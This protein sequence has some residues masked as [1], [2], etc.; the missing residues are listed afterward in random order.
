MYIMCWTRLLG[1]GSTT[2]QINVNTIKWS[3]KSYTLLFI[4]CI[5]ILT[6]TRLT[7]LI[8]LIRLCDHIVCEGSDAPRAQT[9]ESTTY[10]MLVII[11]SVSGIAPE[12]Q[13]SSEERSSF[14]FLFKIIIQPRIRKML[15]VLHTETLPQCGFGWLCHR[16]NK[17]LESQRTRASCRSYTP[18]YSNVCAIG[19][20]DSVIYGMNISAYDGI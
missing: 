5:F 2:N 8:C 12:A 17:K 11:F 20:C 1:L 14:L 3:K 18:R 13:F 19:H 16:V 6:Q 9:C 10:G 4:F 15:V 7:E